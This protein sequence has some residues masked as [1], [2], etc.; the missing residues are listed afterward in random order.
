MTV[1]NF[2][3]KVLI[4][5]KRWISRVPL[6]ACFPWRHTG[7]SPQDNANPRCDK[8]LAFRGR[9]KKIALGQTGRYSRSQISH[10]LRKADTECN[11]S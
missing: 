1:V 8:S 2:S 5:R 3:W 4:G 10:L 11:K 9:L 7:P 6:C